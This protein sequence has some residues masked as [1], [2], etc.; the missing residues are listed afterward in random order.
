MLG[1]VIGA[2]R[3]GLKG[4]LKGAGIG[5]VSGGAGGAGL[6]YYDGSKA[7]EHTTKAVKDM[8]DKVKKHSNYL[9]VVRKQANYIPVIG[10]ALGAGTGLLAGNKFDKAN[11]DPNNPNQNFWDKN[12]GKILMGLSGG[13]SGYFLSKAIDNKLK[14][15]SLDKVRKLI[16]KDSV[17]SNENPEFFKNT[18]ENLKPSFGKKTITN[19][20]PDINDLPGGDDFKRNRE[21]LNDYL[22]KKSIDYNNKVNRNLTYSTLSNLGLTGSVLYLRKDANKK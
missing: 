15:N 20:F 7:S 4:A 16:N 19:V 9:P 18:V 1:A 13:A 11:S 10:T 14:E 3:G 6:G 8:M 22:S 12:K 21:F 17:S 2:A 5:A